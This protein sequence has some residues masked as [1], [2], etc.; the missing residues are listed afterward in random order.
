M[1]ST[2]DFEI[3]KILAEAWP[4][5]VSKRELIRKIWGQDS[6]DSDA[7]RSHIY[8]LR[9]AVDKPFAWP[10]IKTLHGIGFKLVTKEHD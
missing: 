10:M 5:A 2:T 4:A 7:V 8:T 3:L 6:P 9:N 1:L